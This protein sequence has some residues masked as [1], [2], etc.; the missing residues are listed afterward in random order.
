MFFPGRDFQ[1]INIT[2]LLARPTD[3]NLEVYAFRR[4]ALVVSRGALERE[5]PR[6]SI[7]QCDIDGI[8][9]STNAFFVAPTPRSRFRSCSLY[10]YTGTG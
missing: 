5:T 3:E 2:I 9:G 1:A 6:T 4:L 7:M 10:S 8:R